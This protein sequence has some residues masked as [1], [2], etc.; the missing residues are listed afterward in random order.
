MPTYMERAAIS[1]ASALQL[2]EAAI[3]E[4]ARRGIA[5]AVTVVDPGMGLVAAARADGTTPHSIETSRRKATTSAS[6][7]K[8]TG[9]M[10]EGLAVQLPLGTGNL[11]TNIHGGLPLAFDGHHLGGLGVAGGPP[12]KDAEIAATVLDA[13]GYASTGE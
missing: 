5:V 8:P 9:Y 1:H 4:G 7:R 12:A 2:V 13:L 10:D 11:L 3:E 6:T